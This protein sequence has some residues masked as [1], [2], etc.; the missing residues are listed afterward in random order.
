MTEPNPAGA[1]PQ[2][3]PNPAG[4]QQQADPAQ[5]EPKPAGEPTQTDP[6]EPHGTDWKAQ[7]RKWEKLAKA[8]KD[9]ADMWD[10]QKQAAPTVESLQQQLD[11]IRAEAAEQRDAAE[12]DRARYKVAQATG[13]P[14]SLLQGDDEES[15]TASAN[16]IAEYVKAQAPS[17]PAD[18]GAGAHH[19]PVSRE[20]IE[21]I[22]D[23][24]ARIN[25]RAQHID[26]Y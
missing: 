6:P 2:T 21:Q 14:A 26:L 17:Y 5:T 16:A 1:Q 18:K 15:M 22:K 9:K 12:R 25:A 4:A 7:A 3:D 19:A 20:S 8:N 10:A 24:A 13:V 23:P 11:E